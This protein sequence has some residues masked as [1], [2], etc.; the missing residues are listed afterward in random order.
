MSD[1][2]LASFG[3]VEGGGGDSPRRRVSRECEWEGGNCKRDGE[4]KRSSEGGK[5]EN[6]WRGGKERLREGGRE[7]VMERSRDRRGGEGRAAVEGAV[8]E[9]P[10]IVKNDRLA[11]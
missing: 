3:V 2:P 11:H 8:A 6:V 10:P 9:L 1:I 5:A 4:T 7:W